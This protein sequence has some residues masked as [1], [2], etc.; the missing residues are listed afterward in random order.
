ME[1]TLT[2]MK[3]SYELISPHL[4]ERT[5]RLW[6]AAEAKAIG[7]GGIVAV[8]KATG[9][10]RPRITRGKKDLDAPPMSD[11]RIRRTG[12]GRK[13]V[14]IKDST[15]LVD[16]DALIEPMKRGDPMSGIR[17]TCKSTRRLAKEL[18]SQKHRVSHTTVAKELHRQKYSL[19]GNRKTQEG[20]SHPDRNAQFEHIVRWQL[21]FK[22]A[23]TR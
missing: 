3:K 12:G 19:Q 7:H 17:W 15:L 8:Q 1:T 18:C 16:L 13:Y 2:A 6:C 22:N 21:H 10:S 20:S 9:V 4:D 14:T 11:G 23:E 5:R